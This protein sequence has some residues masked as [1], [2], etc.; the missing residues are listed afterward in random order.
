MAKFAPVGPAHLL[1]GIRERW[2]DSVIGN[3]HLLLAH[4]IIANKGE[5]VGVL[6]TDSEVIIDN[7]VI[8]LG[9][10]VGCD[11][12]IQAYDIFLTHGSYRKIIA[13]LPEKLDNP[14]E[15]HYMALEVLQ[16]TQRR[17]LPPD[18]MYV[19]Q[20]LTVQQ[21]NRAFLLV[22]EAIQLGITWISIPRRIV[23]GVGTRMYALCEAIKLQLEYPHIK[24]HLLGFSNNIADDIYCSKY[25][26]VC[27]I[28]S[29]VPLRLGQG[30]KDLDLQYKGDQ[31]GPRGTYWEDSHTIIRLPT[32]ANILLLRRAIYDFSW[33]RSTPYIDFVPKLKTDEESL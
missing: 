4:D 17:L 24:I 27:G 10:S 1:R 25:P 23:D 32:R 29:A 5:W 22:R 11:L 30:G 12:L 33:D 21:L 18:L 9:E 2:G 28:D 13:V 7:S 15:T 31:A 8:E 26:Q 16:G 20:G 14:I 6:P 3:Y 19:I